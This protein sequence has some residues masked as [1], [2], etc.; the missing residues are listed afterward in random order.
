[1]DETQRAQLDKLNQ[2]AIDGIV[3]NE[4]QKL[5]RRELSALQQENAQPPTVDFQPAVD[6]SLILSVNHFIAGKKPKPVTS[7]A[8]AVAISRRRALTALHGKVPLNSPVQITTRNGVHLSGIVEFERF[9]ENM[10]DIAVILLD[11]GSEFS[12]FIPWIDKPVVLTQYITVVG[13]KYGHVGDTV[14]TYARITTVDMIEEFGPRSA[15]FQAQYYSFD[16]CCGAGVVTATVNNI[17]KVVGVHVA[18]HDDTAKAGKRKRKF[19]NFEAS[20]QSDIHGHNAYSLV[21]EIARVPDLVA[22]LNTP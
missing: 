4:E 14:N 12:H 8:S 18:S 9:E 16:D 13:L 20:V 7:T 22:L 19:A 5:I 17:V 1:M 6:A 15:L 21:C 2:M 10:V 11:V 3:L